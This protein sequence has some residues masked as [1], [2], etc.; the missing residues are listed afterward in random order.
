MSFER[1]AFGGTGTVE[2]VSAEA[3]IAGK[4]VKGAPYSAEAVTEN[5]QT[6]PDGNRILESTSATYRDSEGRTRREMSLPPI[7]PFATAGDAPTFMM[8]NDPVAGV[9]YH[10][11]TKT[12]T[13]RKMPAMA[14]GISFGRYRSFVGAI[15]AGA[16]SRRP[17]ASVPADGKVRTTFEAAVPPPAAGL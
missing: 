12:K 14:G 4:V 9:S 6:L 8:I 16:R 7:G 1:H 10:L 2:F 13:A 17:S 11:D 5:T 3:S 15:A